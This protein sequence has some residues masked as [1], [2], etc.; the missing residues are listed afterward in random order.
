[1]IILD[2]CVVLDI[3]FNESDAE[4]LSKFIDDE[5][6]TGND[7]VFLPLTLLESSSVVAVRFK[8]GRAKNRDLHYYLKILREFG[9]NTVL[10]DLTPELIVEAAKI[11]FE[12][13]ASMV[14]CYLIANAQARNAEILTSDSEILK[15]L[16]KKATI[17]KITKK[18]STI[19]WL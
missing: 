5:Q 10:G 6:A 7:V 11:K 18:F 15:F 14:D 8:E 19:R 4:P 2:S 1:M 3:L 12:H 9:E 16:R 17:R 13:A